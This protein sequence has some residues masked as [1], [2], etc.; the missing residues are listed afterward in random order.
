MKTK[1]TKIKLLEFIQFLNQPQS[2]ELSLFDSEHIQKSHAFLLEQTKSSKVIYGYN[3]GFGALGFTKISGRQTNLSQK[4]LIYHLAT[5][6]GERFQDRE[7]LAILLSRILS[8]SKGY[9]GISLE[10]FKKLIYFFQNE[11]IPHIPQIGTVGASGDLTPLAHLALSYMG[12]SFTYWKG[13]TYKQKDFFRANKS[14]PLLLKGRDGLAIVNGT[15]ASCGISALNI[16]EL[17]KA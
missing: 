15:S 2:L 11:V 7:A 9:S 13:K 4:N 16:Y 17:E 1:N 8:L 10:S 12:K 14:S 6:V 5:G 3:T